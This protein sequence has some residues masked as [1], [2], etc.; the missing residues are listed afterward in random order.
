MIGFKADKAPLYIQVKNYICKK[1]VDDIWPIGYKLPLEENLQKNWTLAERQ[2]IL[3][4]KKW[5]RR[6]FYR[7]IRVKVHL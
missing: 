6:V 1:I 7:H 2:S 3:L 4:T 5:K